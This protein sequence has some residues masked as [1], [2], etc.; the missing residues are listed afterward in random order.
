MVSV[1]YLRSRIGVSTTLDIKPELNFLIAFM[2]RPEQKQNAGKSI[3][4]VKHGWDLTEW[5]KIY[6]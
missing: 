1:N 2:C 4:L 3:F 6:G 5:R